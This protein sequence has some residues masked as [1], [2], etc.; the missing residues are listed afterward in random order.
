MKKSLA[1]C[2]ALVGWAAAAFAAWQPLSPRDLLALLPQPP[3]NWTLSVSHGRNHFVSTL[4]TVATREYRGKFP[5][6]AVESV[7]T[8]AIEDT[9]GASSKLEA[10][11]AESGEG[12]RIHGRP[13]LWRESPGGPLILFCVADRF[14][15]K[16]TLKNGTAAQL[17]E[18]MERVNISALTEVATGPTSAVPNPVVL[19]TVDELNP[20]SSRTS[21][22]HWTPKDEPL[23]E[24]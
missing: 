15:L 18:L 12:E 23:T 11:R 8:L 1:F 17:K 20:A 4:G 2:W 13:A 19:V 22:L 9:G 7:W 16:G 6:A 24:P 10:Y 5:D 3:P 14:I 21:T